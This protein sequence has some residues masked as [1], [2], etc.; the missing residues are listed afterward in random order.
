MRVDC[1]YTYTH[2]NGEGMSEGNSH[3][4]VTSQPSRDLESHPSLGVPERV[5]A[6]CFFPIV[7][8]AVKS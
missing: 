5:C 7:K 2:V 3:T 6:A 1:I 4:R 8:E